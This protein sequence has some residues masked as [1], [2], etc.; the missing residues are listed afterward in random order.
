MASVAVLICTTLISTV[1]NMT[2]ATRDCREVASPIAI[3]ATAQ[4]KT[5]ITMQPPPSTLIEGVATKTRTKKLP[6][7]ALDQ[8]ALAA[9]GSDLTPKLTKWAIAKSDKSRRLKGAKK[10]QKRKLP[11]SPRRKSATRDSNRLSSPALQQQ[12]SQKATMWEKLTGIF[13]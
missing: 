2:T 13:N 8:R 9:A 3:T 1:G 6:S 12:P 11:K 5:V 7:K 10:A 4:N